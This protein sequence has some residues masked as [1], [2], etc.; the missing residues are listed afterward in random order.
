MANVASAKTFDIGV[1]GLGSCGRKLART[2]AQQNIGV[3]VC[4]GNPDN[5]KVLQE[6]TKGESIRIAANTEELF[7]L[8]PKGRTIIVSGPDPNGQLFGYLVGQLQAGDLMID[9]GDCHFRDICHREQCLAVRDIRHLAVGVIASGEKSCFGPVLMAG[10]H[11][12]TYN[13]IRSLLEMMA[14]KE[15]GRTH[16][17]HLGPSASGHFVKIVHDGIEFTLKRVIAEA[18]GLLK[19]ALNVDDYALA[20][21]GAVWQT[22]NS[23][24][25]AHLEA[26]RWL[27]QAACELQV[28]APTIAAAAGVRI[29]CDFDRANDFASATFR[30]PFGRLVDEPHSILDELQGSLCTASLVTYAQGMAALAAGSH[31]YGFQL[32]VPDVIALWKGCGPNRAALLDEIASVYQETPTLANL[33]DDDDVSEKVMERQEC[34]RQAVSRA[35][36]VQLPVPALTASL[37]YLD[38]Y[39]GAWLPGNLIQPQ[40]HSLKPP[41]P[42]VLVRR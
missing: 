37:D 16:V 6:E 27:A 34:L 38:S 9:A 10:G 19:N 13:G 4:D 32:D 12:E 15:N 33:L 39:R 1:I 35:G 36:R 28:H 14:L 31:Q 26:A 11:A 18:S 41:R 29:L 42:V 40:I 21:F 5:I 3:D 20:A 8:L 24:D 17:G 7:R 23:P 22:D 2:M 30:Q 25:C